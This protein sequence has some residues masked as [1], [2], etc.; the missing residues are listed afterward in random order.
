MVF[1]CCSSC[2]SPVTFVAGDKGVYLAISLNPPSILSVCGAVL[3][4]TAV[5]FFALHIVPMTNANVIVENQ[6]SK[7][8]E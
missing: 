3:T 4:W 7:T 6:R 1:S 5:F 8:N 2:L